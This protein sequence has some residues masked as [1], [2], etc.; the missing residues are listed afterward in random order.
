MLSQKTCKQ[1][2]DTIIVI[3]GPCSMLTGLRSVSTDKEKRLLGRRAVAACRC[4]CAFMF[5]ITSPVVLDY[6]LL[7]FIVISVCLCPLHMLI[8]FTNEVEDEKWY[9]LFIKV[10][11]RQQTSPTL[12]CSSNYCFYYWLISFL[13][14]S[15]HHLVYNMSPE[16]KPEVP[17]PSNKLQMSCFVLPTAQNPKIFCLQSNKSTTANPHICNQRIFGSFAWQMT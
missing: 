2:T 10:L 8:K 1:V 17:D 6:W 14:L 9:H 11:A 16:R 7:P 5:V 12:K 15:I 3:T 4:F 13:G